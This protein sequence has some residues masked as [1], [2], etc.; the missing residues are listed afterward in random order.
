MEERESN[1]QIKKMKENEEIRWSR[2]TK[3]SK[4]IIREEDYKLDKWLILFSIF[5][6]YRVGM[7]KKMSSEEWNT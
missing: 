7:M 5:I 4:F 3:R 2:D 1:K 6:F